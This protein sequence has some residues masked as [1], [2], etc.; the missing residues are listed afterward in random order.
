MV[1]S[2]L[3]VTQPRAAAGNATPSAPAACAAWQ[4]G[5]A[6]FHRVAGLS[7]TPALQPRAQGLEFERHLALGSHPGK[8]KTLAQPLS[9]LLEFLPLNSVPFKADTALDLDI[10]GPAEDLVGGRSG[11]EESRRGRGRGRQK[12]GGRVQRG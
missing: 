11:G 6:C 10:L 7:G 8:Q 3:L 5:P 12:G 1:A 2:P 9:P 4:P